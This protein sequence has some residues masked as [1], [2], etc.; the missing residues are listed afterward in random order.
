MNLIAIRKPWQPRSLQMER[1]RWKRFQ[2]MYDNQVWNLVDNVPGSTKTLGAKWI[3]KKK[4][5][6]DG[7]VHIRHDWLRRALL[8]LPG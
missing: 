4:T 1:G 2:S 5:E 6:L 8:K 3:F 7:K